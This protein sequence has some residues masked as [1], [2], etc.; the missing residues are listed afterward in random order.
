MATVASMQCK[1]RLNEHKTLFGMALVV[2]VAGL[3]VAWIHR[4]QIAALVARV[5]GR[6][7]AA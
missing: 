6:G 7:A 4:A 5:R 1:V 3:V 2:F